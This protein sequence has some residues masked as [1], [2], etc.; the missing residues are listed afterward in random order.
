MNMLEF[1]LSTIN[2]HLTNLS[3]CTSTFQGIIPKQD[4]ILSRPATGPYPR[5]D[6][7]VPQSAIAINRKSISNPGLSDI[8]PMFNFEEG[9][10]PNLDM[11]MSNCCDVEWDLTIP[12]RT[13]LKDNSD[14]ETV[15]LSIDTIVVL[16]DLYVVLILP[17]SK[18]Y[19]SRSTLASHILE[20][21]EGPLRDVLGNNTRVSI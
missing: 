18:G 5:D 6:I 1:F 4:V 17:S 12:S 14:F 19:K 16:V 7:V 11:S 8:C 9:L 2:S 21:F 15:Q 13:T 3:I 10:R 20:G